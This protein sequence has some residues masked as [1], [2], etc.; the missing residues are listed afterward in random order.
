M[1]EARQW[2]ST[3]TERRPWRLDLFAASVAHIGAATNGKACRVLELGSGPGVLAQR[4][5]SEIPAIEYVGLDFSGAMHD[6]ARERLGPMSAR[7]TFIERDL[8][9]P[10][11]WTGLG[12][13]FDFVVTHQAVH[14]L[15]HKR[16]APLLHS[17]VKNTLSSGGSYLVCDHFLGEGGMSNDQLYMTVAEQRDALLAGGFN[18]VS[19]VLLKGDLVLHHAT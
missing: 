8:K 17:Q 4:L 12:S 14:E 16:H 15:R 11:W 7:A 5:L 9:Q 3:T 10:E 1:E 19:Q 6:L 18:N 2:S 13:S